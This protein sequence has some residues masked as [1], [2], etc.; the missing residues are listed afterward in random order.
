MKNVSM[1]INE[2]GILTISVDLSKEYGPSKSG[3]NTI[4]SSSEG[5]I[6]A[7]E[8]YSDVKVGINIYKTKQGG[9]E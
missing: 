9:A 7:P 1:T 3:K 4:I 5:N 8:P 2:S 6:S